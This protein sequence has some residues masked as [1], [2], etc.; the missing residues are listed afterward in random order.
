VRELDLIVVSHG[1]DDHA[2]GVAAIRAR[3]PAT[4]VLASQPLPGG[5]RPCQAGQQWRWDGVDFRVLHPAGSGDGADNERSCV[6]EVRAPGGRLLL[7]GDIGAPTERALVAAGVLRP[8]EL[9]V[10]PHHGSRG[11]STSELVAALRP[12][13]VVF[14]TGFANRWDF[15]RP[16]VVA[17]W[18]AAGS[19]AWDTAANGALDFVADPEQGVVFAGSGRA[20]GEPVWRRRATVPVCAHRPPAAAVPPVAVYSDAGL[21]AP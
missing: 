12:R 10:A 2:G 9:V 1:D 16:D 6:L 19:C 4:P 14:T 15:P 13:H 18:R 3:H 5:W 17:R 8:A 7:T 20:N 11:S 21:V